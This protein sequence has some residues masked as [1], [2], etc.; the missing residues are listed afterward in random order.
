L[1]R[2]PIYIP[3][4]EDRMEDLPDIVRHIIMKVNQLYGRNV[5]TISGEAMVA[6]RQYQWPGN[7]RELENVISR[8]IIFMDVTEEII[9]LHHLPE[10]TIAYESVDR[11]AAEENITLQQATENFEREF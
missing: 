11:I 3:S 10:L 9:E 5:R 1:N 8:A 4:L 2:L 6:L 7:I